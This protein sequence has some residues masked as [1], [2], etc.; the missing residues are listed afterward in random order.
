M[1]C[2]FCFTNA[3]LQES[4]SPLNVFC[5]KA[6]QEI[7]YAFIAA[8]GKRTREDEK[9][10]DPQDPV[11]GFNFTEVVNTDV[12][13]L[14]MQRFT[15]ADMFKLSHLNSRLQE[16]C[17]DPQFQRMYLNDTKGK[18]MFNTFVMDLPRQAPM[19][20]RN[21][22]TW[23]QTAREL[24]IT[25][26]SQHL[27]SIGIRHNDLPLVIQEVES[28]GFNAKTKQALIDDALQY[29]RFSIFR[30]LLS[31][32]PDQE[33][34]ME[35]AIWSGNIDLMRYLYTLENV[36]TN[37]SPDLV[38]VIDVE[39]IYDVA[40]FLMA[41]NSFTWTVT[42]V[43]RVVQRDNS[44]FVDAFFQNVKPP[45]AAVHHMIKVKNAMYLRNV[46]ILVQYLGDEIRGSVI[47]SMIRKSYL[48]FP[49]DE[50][51]FRWL[52]K[53]DSLSND[54]KITVFEHLIE[55][56]R[57]DDYIERVIEWMVFNNHI[58]P[59]Y[60]D[61]VLYHRYES[62]RPFLL[63]FSQVRAAVLRKELLLE[64]PE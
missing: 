38:A 35:N 11:P 40:L 3:K 16:M 7:H 31:R 48:P 5:G 60:D 57:P 27:I 32:F 24:K 55:L 26:D 59:S 46:V 6:C 37:V 41:K 1:S 4:T 56:Y 63:K 39:H 28:R 51:H 29:G 19:N 8:G 62:M 17:N 34:K 18:A 10:L 64:S 2:L 23:I 43:E 21:L 14:L 54:D 20:I 13:A 22:K 45:K 61:N 49:R 30:Y 47:A 12:L 33:I 9:E 25:F 36:N 42:L 58:D 50:E 44:V 52:V 15:F 53:H